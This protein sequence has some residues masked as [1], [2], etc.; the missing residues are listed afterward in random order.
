MRE[1]KK[2]VFFLIIVTALL[3]VP[4]IC[5]ATDYTVSDEDTFRSTV[6]SAVTG[7]VVK[8]TKD[9]VLTSPITITDKI[10]TIDGNGH[11]IS[12]D[13]TWASGTQGNQSL[14][15]V[16][17]GGNVTLKNLTLK[18]SKKY[19]VQAFDTGY[20]I[21]DGVTLTNNKYGGALVNGGNLEIVDVT[22]GRNG[23]DDNVGIEI[24][25]GESAQRDPVVIMNGTLASSESENVFW[26]AQNDNLEKFT[27]ENTEDS[28]YK[29]LSNGN[30]I[31]VADE[32]NQILYASNESEKE[33]EISPD[34][35]IES[36]IITIEYDGETTQF[37]VN[38]GDK[39]SSLD[40]TEIKD[41]VVFSENT[42]INEDILLVAVYK[43]TPKE[44]V[45][46][47]EK[48]LDKSDKNGLENTEVVIA[49]AMAIVALI[50]LV[51]LKKNK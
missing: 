50:G 25:R 42:P 20:V 5:K 38:K 23:E 24:S 45:K 7:D 48:E 8:L 11:S 31:F 40:L 37:A 30:Q 10:I 15:T 27:V 14:I 32:N 28:E 29:L 33:I 4:S 22:L 2:I 21:L 9:I 18:N 12:A 36:A 1:L 17:T 35:S 43:D 44:E 41:G 16:S 47:P 49:T 26:I 19:G 46:E 34:E 39:L 6:E 51:E 3:L 13:D